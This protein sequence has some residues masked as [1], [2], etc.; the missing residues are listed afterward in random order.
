VTKKRD[1]VVCNLDFNLLLD[2]FLLRL[3][4]GLLWASFCTSLTLK[5]S[6]EASGFSDSTS[7][8]SK[9]GF[10]FL[11]ECLFPIKDVMSTTEF[12]KYINSENVQCLRP[13]AANS[14][15]PRHEEQIQYEPSMSKTQN[16]HLTN[17]CGFKQIQDCLSLKIRKWNL[18]GRR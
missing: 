17:N 3:D 7:I 9:F 4:L 1:R 5:Y 18:P 2:F 11:L 15:Q 10:K 14:N 8:V 13:L 12:F 6:E 16:Q